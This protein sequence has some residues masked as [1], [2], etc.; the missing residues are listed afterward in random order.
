METFEEDDPSL[1]K[2]LVRAEEKKIETNQIG[3]VE[4]TEVRKDD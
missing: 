2:P 1:P 4:L 3:S